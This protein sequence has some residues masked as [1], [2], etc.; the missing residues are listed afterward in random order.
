[1]F[2]LCVDLRQLAA[3]L[4][5]CFLPVRCLIGVFSG[6]CLVLRS[7]CWVR[8]SCLLCFTFVCKECTVRCDM[9]APQHSVIGC[10]F[11][12]RFYGPVNPRGHVECGQFT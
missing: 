7:S 12:L 5:L 6:F 11:V 1:M 4:F 3:E 10:L 8:E 9:F 2:A